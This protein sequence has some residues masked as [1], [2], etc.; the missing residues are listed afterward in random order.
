VI[1][2][3]NSEESIKNSTNALFVDN[4][5]E[6]AVNPFQ[7]TQGDFS[8][9]DNENKGIVLSVAD[10]IARVKGLHNVGAN[11]TVIFNNSIYGI[12]LSLEEDIVAIAILDDETGVK[13]GDIVTATFKNIVVPT[14]KKLLGRVIDCLGRPIDGQ[15]PLLENDLD[16]ANVE[17]NAPGI[18]ERQS[19]HQP[20]Q[21]GIKAVDALL[22]IGRGQ[23]ELIIGDRQTGK[24]TIAIDTIINQKS[25]AINGTVYCVYVAIGQKK[26]NV[27][28]IQKTLA[29]AGAMEYTVIVSAS[30]DVSAGQQFLAPYAGCAVAEWF[31][32]KGKHALVVY[33]DLSKH[34][35][36][37][38]QV[39]LLVR[40]PPG[41]EAFP[42][43]VFY[44]HSRLLERAAKLSKKFGA[45]SITALP[46]V[47][48]QAG[49]VSAYIPTNVISITDGQIFLDT[50]LFNSGIRPAI[51]IGL[52]VSRVGS[53]AQLKSYKRVAGSLKL[54]LAQFREV[55]D[56]SKFGSDLDEATLGI[57]RRGRQLTELMIQPRYMPVKVYDQIMAI[58]MGSK[59][60][61]DDIPPQYI[62]WQERYILSFLSNSELLASHKGQLPFN[63]DPRE[64]IY[65]INLYK[66]FKRPLFD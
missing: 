16:F 29:K 65:L 40:R 37:Y 30:A 43:D 1:G 59:G 32:R 55:E 48:T 6:L 39:S 4:I 28:E 23:R 52:S 50:G 18:V 60:F 62:T 9:V 63:Y 20:L 10:G 15:G 56:F 36:A 22:P 13:E 19:V 57:L 8:S 49:D 17:E 5:D 35:V 2:I 66:N 7:N 31:M 53:A 61:L 47:E 46:I 54:D 11:E 33:D 12:I 24:T 25:S 64:L 27:L 44:L 26:S 14:G 3:I 58:H 42:G 41:R 34:A 51:N 45:G 38:R 21:T